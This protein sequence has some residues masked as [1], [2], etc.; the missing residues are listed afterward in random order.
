VAHAVLLLAGWLV[1]LPAGA[2]CTVVSVRY[3]H[4]LP[5][6]RTLDGIVP[7]TSTAADAVAALGVPE[8]FASPNPLSFGSAWD[9]ARQRVDQE[10]DLLDRRVLS[11]VYETRTRREFAFLPS[12]PLLGGLLTFYSDSTLVHVDDRIVILLDEQGV[13]TAVGRTPEPGS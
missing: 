5:E 10:R 2:G 6:A 1:L 7:G 4:A 9:P 8:D 3:G 12:L 11:W 13:V